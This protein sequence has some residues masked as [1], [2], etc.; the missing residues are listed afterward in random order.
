MLW[1]YAV[2]ALCLFVCLPFFLH[3]K[4]LLRYRLAAA[5]KTLG[6]LCAAVPA[7]IAA[8][9]LDPHCWICFAA[10]LI[11]AIADYLLEFNFY[12]GT[13]FFLAGHICYIG[14]FS[15]LF[16]VSVVHLAAI[17]CLLGIIAFLLWRWRVPAGK[18]MPLFIVYGV[19]LCISCG[20]AIAG[21]TAH[22]AQGQMIAAGG[23]LFFISDAMLLAR[24]LFSASHGVDWAIMITYYAAQLLFGCSCVI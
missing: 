19:A 17:F 15:S 9:R 18:R 12:L 23:A 2:P 13:G 11:H 6:T 3:Y 22:T 16:P 10:L 1:I 14:F 4:Q 24:L 21:L 7:L 8:I 20:F 5:Y